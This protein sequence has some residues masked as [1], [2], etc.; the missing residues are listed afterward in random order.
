M[1]ERNCQGIVMIT[2]LLEQG[3]REF[4]GFLSDFCGHYN[5][6]AHF[7]T[8]LFGELRCY[9]Y[10][11][12]A[13]KEMISY[14]SPGFSLSFAWVPLILLLLGPIVLMGHMCVVVQIFNFLGPILASPLSRINSI[15]Q[16]CF[17]P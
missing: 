10:P 16:I 13:S 15:L 9:G 2:G 12:K 7:F 17:H 5:S 8:R 4:H 11:W 6:F 14:I 1:G 3:E